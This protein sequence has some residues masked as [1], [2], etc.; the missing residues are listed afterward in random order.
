MKKILIASGNSHK[1]K[2]ISSIV[3]DIPN[4]EV[5]TLNNFGICLEVEENGNTLEQ[6]ALIKAKSVYS[7]LGMPVISDDTGLFVNALNG[8]PGIYSARYAGLNAAY[9][10][11]CD[12]LLDNLKEIDDDNLQAEFKCCI[13]LLINPEEFYFFEG[14]CRGRICRSPK[15]ENGFGYDPVFMPDGFEK[16]FAELTDDEKNLISHRGRALEKL[17]GFLINFQ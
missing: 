4:L 16:T 14:I 10:D 11:N 17:K 6:N 15:G 9:K 2:E 13:C 5:T 3:S 1:I 7:L 12:K 8:E